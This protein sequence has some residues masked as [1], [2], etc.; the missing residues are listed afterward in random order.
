METPTDRSRWEHPGWAAAV[1]A[2]S[3]AFLVLH[4]QWLD[5]TWTPHGADWDTWY[6]GALAIGQPGVPYPP[7]RWPIYSL[8]AATFGLL[9]GPLHVNA[10]VASMAATASAAAGLFLI[11]RS[12]LGFCGALA[13]AVL[14]VASPMVILLSSWISSYPLWAAGAVWAVAGMVEALRTRQRGWWVVAGS[15]VA[16]VLAVQAK[17]LGIGLLLVGVL[18]LSALLDWRTWLGN[19]AR[20]AAPVL[21]M[22]LVYVAFPSPLLTLQAQIQMAEVGARPQPGGVAPLSL[23]PD[24]QPFDNGYVFGRSMGPTMLYQTIVEARAATSTDSDRRRHES[25]ASLQR[26]FPTVGSALLWWMLLGGILGGVSGCITLL[27]RRQGAALAGWVGVA[28]IVAGVLPSLLSHLSIRFLTPVFFV[29][30]LFV[31]APVALISRWSSRS[32]WLPLLLIPIALVPGSPWSDS[33]WLHAE[34]TQAQMSSVLIPGHDAVRLWYELRQRH[35]SAAIH[36]AAPASQGLLVLDGRTGT[37]LT[38]DPRF[39]DQSESGIPPEDYLLRWK[40]D[41]H[42]MNSDMPPIVDP[43]SFSDRPELESFPRQAGASLVLLGVQ[44]VQ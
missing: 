32:A 41:A 43:P 29:A 25:I 39:H 26:T 12:L 22:A 38:P 33:P 7:N 37:F 20:A 31:V 2:V 8:F 21:L 9:P 28:G 18:A 1:F 36:V 44:S 17:G 4:Q 35:P 15:G 34:A 16:V 14:T 42:P 3:L 10:A 24:A 19:A 30:P 40:E 11:S 6:Q 5:S 27:R 13:V 23:N